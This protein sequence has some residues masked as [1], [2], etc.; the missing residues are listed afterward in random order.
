MK[1]QATHIHP[2]VM[3]N[4]IRRCL[5]CGTARNMARRRY[6]SLTC[7]Q[8]LRD[9]LNRR[10]GLLKAL[11]VRYATFYFTEQM[12][13]LDLL[14]YDMDRIHSF[15]LIRSLRKK[16][17]EE[18]CKLAEILGKAWWTERNR[19]QRR[20]LAS[21]H[22]LSKARSPLSETTTVAPMELIVPSVKGTKLILLHLDEHHLSPSKLAVRI[23]EAYRRQAK[24]Y[25]PDLGGDSATFRRIHDA[26]ENLMEWSKKP[27]FIKRSGFPDKW[28][29]SGEANRW[30]QPTPAYRIKS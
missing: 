2:K 7:R 15:I 10:T 6:C 5:S 1:A 23:K 18:F 4:S 13:L 16:P 8:N 26:Y 19:T 20:Y 28:F 3:P 11:N 14:P 21:R 29:Y 17:V 25:H 24:K 12:V 30:V 22:V 9:S 27:T